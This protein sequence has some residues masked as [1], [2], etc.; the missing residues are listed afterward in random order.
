MAIGLILVD[1][2]N[3]YFPGGRMELVGIHQASRNAR[4]VLDL[5]RDRGWPLFHV[6]HLAQQAD[7]PLFTPGTPFVEIHENVHPMPGEPVVQKH[8]PNSFHQ[9][10]LLESLKAAGVDHAV[11]VGAMSHMCIDA[12]TRAAYD[13]GLRCTLIHDACTTRD[14]EFQGKKV[15]ADE[16]HAAFMSALGWW[17]AQLASTV[18]FVADAR[19]TR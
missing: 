16:V 4:Q 19:K 3:E 10:P 9:T 6:Q 18:D 11:I 12:T 5:F 14:L 7:S 8:F 1:I 17:Y 15:R 2:Q 13:L